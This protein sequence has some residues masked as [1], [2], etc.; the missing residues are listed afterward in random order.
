M[1]SIKPISVGVDEAA[2]MLGIVTSLF[3]Q[4]VANGLLP[5]SRAIGRRSVWLVAELEAAGASWALL[6]LKGL[7]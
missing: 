2:A 1:I 5:R 3:L 6:N 4:Q 7:I